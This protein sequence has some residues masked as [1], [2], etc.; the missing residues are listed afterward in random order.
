MTQAGAQWFPNDDRCT[1]PR[2]LNSSPDIPP[3]DG[4]ILGW[5]APVVMVMRHST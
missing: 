1:D 3:A 4:A 5:S 2:H